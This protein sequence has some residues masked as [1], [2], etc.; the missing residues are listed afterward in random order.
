MFPAAVPL[1]KIIKSFMQ[2][3]FARNLT[4]YSAEN[5]VNISANLRKTYKGNF[6]NFSFEAF[7]EYFFLQQFYCKNDK[8]FYAEYFCKKLNRLKNLLFV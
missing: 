1:E 6:V 8:K 4:A 2:N 7:A 5:Y 3:I